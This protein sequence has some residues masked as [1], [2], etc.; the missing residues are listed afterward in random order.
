M[1]TIRGSPFPSLSAFSASLRGDLRTHPPPLE[2]LWRA[3][4]LTD[5]Q[6][7]RFPLSYSM[8]IPRSRQNTRITTRLHKVT[9][10]HARFAGD[11][12]SLFENARKLEIRN[13]KF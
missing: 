5:S 7:H 13:P 1:K 10:W 3:G 11:T 9:A 2:E 8:P 4:G 12:E 6:T